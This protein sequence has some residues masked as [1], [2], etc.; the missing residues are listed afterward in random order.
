MLITLAKPPVLDRLILLI[1]RAKVGVDF[2]FTVIGRYIKRLFISKE[3]TN[4]TH[5]LQDDNSIFLVRFVASVTGKTY[6][7][8]NKFVNKNVQDESFKQ[9]VQ[10][11]CQ[12]GEDSFKADNEV[13][14]ARRIGGCAM[15]GLTKPKVIVETGVSKR[16]GSCVI[17]SALLRNR[18][19][20]FDATYYVTHNNAGADLLFEPPHAQIRKILYENSIEL[21][22]KLTVPFDI[23]TNNSDHSTNYEAAEYETI[24][25]QLSPSSFIIAHNAHCHV[26]LSAF[27]QKSGR[28]SLYFQEVLQNH[29]YPGAGSAVTFH[30]A[31]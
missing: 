14:L 6:E 12:N 28:Q 4:L 8:V 1:Y 29:R 3:T 16:P 27:L 17:A 24:Q 11:L 5:R 30:K 26:K 21:P 22:K 23:F 20:G 10:G 15:I 7:E 19:E 2:V 9:Y 25:N 31:Q 13:R 18:S